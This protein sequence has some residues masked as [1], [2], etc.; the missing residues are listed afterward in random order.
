MNIMNYITYGLYVLSVRESDKDS[1]CMINT[2]MQQTSQPEQVS[3]TVNKAN[4]TAEILS[5]TR[6]ASV[7]MLSTST[8]FEFIKG[9]GMRSGR[10]S[11]K[12]DG[13]EAKR[14]ENGILVPTASIVGYLNIEVKEM[15]DLGTHIQF[16]CLVTG[17]EVFGGKPLTYAYYHANVKPRPAAQAGSDDYVCT[18]CGYVR[19]GK[20]EADYVCP[21]CKHGAEVFVKAAKESLSA[22]ESAGNGNIKEM[23]SMR[24]R[25]RGRQRARVLPDLQSSGRKIR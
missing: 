19:K 5:R 23:Y 25:S 17:S 16:L 13:V 11:D 22:A 4:Y 10:D 20:P 6:K 1:G 14:A 12:F 7:A 21:I 2:L 9:F 3:V 24:L 18:I 8:S 15:I